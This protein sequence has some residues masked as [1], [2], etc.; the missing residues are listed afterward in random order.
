MELVLAARRW[1]LI[2]AM[3]FSVSQLEPAI[4]SLFSTSGPI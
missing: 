1:S 3:V 2:S 4:E